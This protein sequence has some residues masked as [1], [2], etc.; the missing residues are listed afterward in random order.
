MPPL[1]ATVVVPLSLPPP[2]LVPMAAVT[3]AVLVV[4]LLNWSSNCTVTAGL[5]ATPATALVGCCRNDRCWG[6]AGLTLMVPL[7]PVMLLAT[8][9]VAVIVWLPAVLSVAPFVNVRVPLVSG[10]LADRT[11]WPSVLVK[12]T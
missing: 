11:A 7:V 8:V 6:A 12:W 4:R 2:G 5:M 10:L 9:S 3:L 1:A